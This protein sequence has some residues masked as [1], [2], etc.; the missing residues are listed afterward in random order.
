MTMT[1][2]HTQF[3]DDENGETLWHMQ[4]QGD[5]LAVPREIDFSILF[6]EQ[7]QAL[8]FA[9]EL[10]KK[11]LKVSLS[12][13]EQNEEFPFELQVHQMMEANHPSVSKFE[14]V[15]VSGAKQYGGVGDGWGCFAQS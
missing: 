2:D 7:G 1:R 4:E 9:Q 10:L 13:D 6:R 12:D 8:Q 11:H 14:A 15:L 5:N 3:P